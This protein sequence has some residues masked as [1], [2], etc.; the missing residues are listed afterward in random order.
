MTTTTGQPAAPSVARPA[1]PRRRGRS[2]RTALGGALIVVGAI[3]GF[4]VYDAGNNREPVIAIA[5]AVP[6][7]QHVTTA[8]LLQV[9]LPAD[10]GLAVVGWSQ[11]SEVV[12]LAAT[13][14]NSDLIVVVTGSSL[15]SVR[16]TARTLPL[17]REELGLPSTRHASGPAERLVLV[18]VAPDRPYDL[19]EI[20]R[21]CS[22]EVIG[23]LPHDPAATQVWTD[24]A[25]PGR[26][27]RRSAL[28]RAA[29][30][31]AFALTDRATALRSVDAPV[32]TALRHDGAIS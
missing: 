1:A 5:R 16:A 21:A 11:A 31:L 2:R 18:V 29:L 13:L 27:F 24:G 10:S 3:A 9:A 8:D 30:D 17:I 26:S 19:A 6:F 15:R 12:G 28:Q 32:A 7:G 25:E 20:A 22:T 4:A 14:R 23:S